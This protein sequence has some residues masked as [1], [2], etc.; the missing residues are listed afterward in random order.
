[1]HLHNQSESAPSSR[2]THGA[3]LKTVASLAL[4]A[5]GLLGSAL[6]SSHR[7]APFV[8]SHPRV[9]GTDFYL[10]TS[11]EP[12]RADYVTAIAN[13]LPLQ[14]A[15]GG[16]NY[17]AL[18]PEAVYDLHFD[19]NGDALEDWTFRFRFNQELKGIALNIGAPGSEKSVPV[20]LRQVGPIS[21]PGDANQNDLESYQIE[22]I[23]GP[24]SA[25]ISSTRL[26]NPATGTPNFPKPIDNIGNKTIADYAAYAKA[27]EYLVTLP[28][29]ERARVFVGQRK[30][31]FVVNLGETFDL[32]NNNPLGPIDAKKNSLADKNVTAL[33][34]EL[35]KS[36]LRSSATPVI[37]GWT[38][39]SLPA[40]RTLLAQP[41]FGQPEL[42]STALQQVSR[43]GMPL[44]NE[45]VIGLPD[46]NK[47]NASHPSNDA[48]FADYVT[49]PTLPA[50][51]E[52]LFGV[53]AP[54]LFPRADL[55][56]VFLTGVPGLN[57]NGS[58]AE[59]LRLNLDTPPTR[60][61]AQK[62]LGVL[63]GDN[64]GFPNGRRPGDDVVD[65]ALRVVMGVLLDASVAPS[66]QLPYT[67]GA[68]LSAL[69]Y[70][71]G[72]PYL[73]TPLAGAPQ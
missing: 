50:L 38:S 44:V 52:A 13:Y 55:V 33:I 70:A 29:G 30:D 28:N 2:P 63:A 59:M 23:Q 66:G 26:I 34:L 19:N 67:D 5:L 46:K 65:A 69:D 57:Q 9:D 43:L 47:F 24:V 36:F 62:N 6:A 73:L 54:K 41:T 58:V 53:T 4:P 25:P 3:S 7:E 32:V 61:Q 39:A 14:D 72:F 37:G 21:G 56:Q 8:T 22:L 49:H 1:M 20:P 18:D 10:F 71:P 51:L 17:F 68:T 48:Q 31:P 40:Q 16:P 45:V 60:L 27:F 64:A 35:P 11:Y 42:V 15:Y 12:G